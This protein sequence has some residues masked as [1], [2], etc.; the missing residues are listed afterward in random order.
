MT[1]AGPSSR[2]LRARA[3]RIPSK[4]AFDLYVETALPT[5]AVITVHTKGDAAFELMGRD[6]PAGF[7][8]VDVGRWKQLTGDED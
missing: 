7:V 3:A 6:Y 8:D 4:F 2:H 1:P 5:T